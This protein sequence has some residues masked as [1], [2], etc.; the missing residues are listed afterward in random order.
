MRQTFGKVKLYRSPTYDYRLGLHTQTGFAHG[1]LSFVRIY[2]LAVQNFVMFSKKKNKKHT[3]PHQLG[4]QKLKAT[5][6]G[7]KKR[8]CYHKVMRF[9]THT[10]QIC[11]VRKC[12]F[13]IIIFQSTVTHAACIFLA[14]SDPNSNLSVLT[15]SQKS[16]CTKIILFRI[17]T[18]LVG[19][20]Q[21]QMGMRIC[22]FQCNT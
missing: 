13:Y 2:Q 4:C 3:P 11:L 7:K 14:R 20:F 8:N 17:I 12:Y 9:K 18:Y 16:F 5:L 10:E 15:K 19:S 22:T 1:L 6:L 21:Y